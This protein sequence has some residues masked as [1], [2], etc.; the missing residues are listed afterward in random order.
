MRAGRTQI[1]ASQEVSEPAS[2]ELIS[3]AVLFGTLLGV[4]LI[5]WLA[6][7]VAQSVLDDHAIDMSAFI[8][9]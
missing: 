1:H 8:A 7:S 9:V 3:V 4:V 5:G 6:M 2:R